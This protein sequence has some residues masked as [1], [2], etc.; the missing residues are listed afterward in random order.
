MPKSL[1]LIFVVA[2]APARVLPMGSLI[3]SVGPSTSSTTS[4]VTPCSVR[5]PVPFALR[6]RGVDAGHVDRRLD[7]GLVGR[8]GIAGRLAG[9]R[10]ELAAHGA[11]HHVADREADRR[12]GGIELPGGGAAG[13]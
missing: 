7:L 9:E 13:G 10:A 8:L 12:V 3:T 2:C 1:R 11:D 5:S 4:F 6:V